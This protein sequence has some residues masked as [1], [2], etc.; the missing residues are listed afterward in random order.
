MKILKTRELTKTFGG[1]VAVDSVD[2]HLQDKEVV[3][4]IGP[5]GSGKTTLINLIAGSL[6][7]DSGRVEFNGEDI[8]SLPPNEI[9]KRGICKTN[10]IPQPFQK[11]T[12]T[13]SVA[14]GS[15]YG[16]DLDFSME[17]ARADALKWLEF[18]GI[19][20]IADARGEQLTHAEARHLEIARA[21]TTRPRVL[22]LDEVIAGLG[23]EE[24]RET[25]N[26]IN[27]IADELDITICWVEHVIEAIKEI[28]DRVVVL[29]FGE[30][31]AD[32]LPKEVLS[33]PEVQKAYL[34]G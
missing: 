22:L 1:L 3:G 32:G 28:V 13:D 12:V 2:F 30:K 20:G 15:L 7:K 31:I 9:N 19:R 23:E 26:V 11:M 17:D 10:Q 29:N 25:L 27:S 16:S 34:G 33:N 18:V 14:V 21:L 5:N 6:E 24:I 8:T 4:L